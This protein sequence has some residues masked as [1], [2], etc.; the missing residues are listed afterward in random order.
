MQK[1]SNLIYIN[2]DDL[3]L[4]IN[5]PR[6]GELYNGSKNEEDLIEYLLFEEA[7]EEIAKAIVK[8]NEFYEDKA[9]VNNGCIK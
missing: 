3:K 8:R 2:L 7:A 5:N 6:F 4:D 1:R 9:L